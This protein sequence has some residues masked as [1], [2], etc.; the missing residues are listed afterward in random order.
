MRRPGKI[1]FTNEMEQ[2]LE[3][4]A[5]VISPR[6]P[7]WH[8]ASQGMAPDN[9]WSLSHALGALTSQKAKPRSATTASAI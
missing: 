2:K 5:F 3:S 8:R 9:G 1:L 7:R 6:V 4:D